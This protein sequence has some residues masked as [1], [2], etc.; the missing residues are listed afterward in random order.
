MNFL[1]FTQMECYRAKQKLMLFSIWKILKL[2]KIL[3]KKIKK[4]DKS[5]VI[6][7]KELEILF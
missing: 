6:K 1:D 5:N 2:L 3:G 7:E 4:G